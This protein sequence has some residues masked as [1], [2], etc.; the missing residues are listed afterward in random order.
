M[1]PRDKSKNAPAAF[2][3]PDSLTH[4]KTQQN[5]QFKNVFQTKMLLLL[6]LSQTL[7]LS[8]AEPTADVTVYYEALCGD[9]IKWGNMFE[10]Y[11]FFIINRILFI[12]Y[13]PQLC[14]D[15]AETR[16]GDVWRRPRHQLQALWKS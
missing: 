13:I 2:S 16:L 9:S 7:S 1:L 14:D 15:S 11:I 12:L 8:S 10:I 4:K 6:L 3:Q 5:S